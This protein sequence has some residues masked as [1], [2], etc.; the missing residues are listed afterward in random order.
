MGP[1][2]AGTKP[3]AAGAESSVLGRTSAPAS[4]G[5]RGEVGPAG[6]ME[7]RPPRDASTGTLDSFVPAWHA[8]V[9]ALDADVR[10]RGTGVKRRSTAR[11]DPSRRPLP[12]T[13]TKGIN[14]VQYTSTKVFRTLLS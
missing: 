3:V 13:T 11:E 8:K 7:D 1:G 5:L 9:K 14:K 10:E 2:L 6:L 4:G 12:V